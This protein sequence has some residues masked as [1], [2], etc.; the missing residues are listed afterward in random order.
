MT[1]H[2]I[3]SGISYGTG[4]TG[5]V[6]GMTFGQWL[7]LIGALVMVGTFLVNLYYRRHE[8]ILAQAENAR[9]AERH[10]LEIAK[11]KQSMRSDSRAEDRA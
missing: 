7:S 4:F 1:Q 2:D 8:K 6:A 10:R 3:T 5:F 11:I 9:K